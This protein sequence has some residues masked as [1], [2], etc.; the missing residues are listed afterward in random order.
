MST[1]TKDTFGVFVLDDNEMLCATI[2]EW[3][4]R[5]PDIAWVAPVTDWHQAEKVA[6]ERQPDV[7]LL[8][9]DLP[10][11]SG[12]DLIEPILKAAPAARILML[13]GLVTRPQIE[14]A[15]DLGASGYLVKDQEAGKIAQM[16][17][18]VMRGEIVLCTTVLAVWSGK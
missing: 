11:T 6:R 1:P 8:D 15:L 5:E 4:E 12:L 7:V 14:K 3:L 17:R 9:I 2:R 10:G 18:C 13:S 16:I